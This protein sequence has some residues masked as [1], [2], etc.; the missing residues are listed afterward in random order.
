MQL[1]DAQAAEKPE[2]IKERSAVR[3]FWEGWKRFGKKAG[4]IQARALLT[5]FYFV[6]LSPFA[7]AVRWW[8]DPLAIKPRSAKGWRPRRDDEETPR[9]RATRQF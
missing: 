6:L 1:E 2:P 5:F 4:D 3:R 7:L 8:S 9:E